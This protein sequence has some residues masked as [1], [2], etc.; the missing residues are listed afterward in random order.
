MKEIYRFHAEVCR[1]I[2]H[3]KRL[4][5]LNL[6]RNGERS[7]GELAQLMEISPT[8]VSQQLAVLGGLAGLYLYLDKKTDVSDDNK[9]LIVAALGLGAEVGVILPFS[10]AH[11]K[12]ADVIGM[13]RL[14]G[15]YS[16]P[17]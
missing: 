12:E 17:G 11:E 4:E 2:A 14:M 6:L 10:R 16:R 3:P 13:N 7:V 1:S 5:I 15:T 9:A 8:N